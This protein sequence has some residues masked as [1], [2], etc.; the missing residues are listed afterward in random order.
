MKMTPE[1]R[2]ENGKLKVARIEMTEYDEYRVS[3]LGARE[4]DAYYT[5]DAED[6]IATA[7]LMDLQVGAR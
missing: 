6:A 7:R 2:T 4:S 3:I 5:S 1:I